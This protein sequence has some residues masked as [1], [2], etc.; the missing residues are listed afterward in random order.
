MT[1]SRELFNERY[2]QARER[3]ERSLWG[4]VDISFRTKNGKRLTVSANKPLTTP[5]DPQQAWKRF[6]GHLIVMGLS[7]LDGNE[8][9]IDMDEQRLIFE[10]KKATPTVEAT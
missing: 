6:K 4:R 8:I 2:S 5:F 1:I 3:K 10:P 7:F 9:T